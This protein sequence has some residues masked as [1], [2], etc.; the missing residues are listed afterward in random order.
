[1]SHGAMIATIRVLAV[2]CRWISQ[3][4]RSPACPDSSASTGS[5]R[6][7]SSAAGNGRV[8]LGRQVDRPV[9]EH[10]REAADQVR[11]LR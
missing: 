1:M 9:Q 4:A 8:H 11:S 2:R 7:G 10:S 3:G 5:L 6:S